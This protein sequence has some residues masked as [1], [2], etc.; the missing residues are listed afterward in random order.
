MSQKPARR[1]QIIRTPQPAPF[2]PSRRQPA[3][4][5]V[6]PSADGC[7]RCGA[8]IS[9][10]DTHATFHEGLDRADRWMQAA[11]EFLQLLAAD[12]P[13]LGSF[14]A[15]GDTASDGDNTTTDGK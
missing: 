1:M 9:D 8:L 12:R 5:T 13:E 14:P 15:Q 2:S 4:R 3:P 10:R 6:P 7:P 11:T